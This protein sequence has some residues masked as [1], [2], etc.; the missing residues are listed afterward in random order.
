MGETHITRRGLVAAGGIGAAVAA[1]MLASAD[2][3]MAEAPARPEGAATDEEAANLAI[4]HGFIDSWSDKDFD[5][6][7]VM[8]KYFT[9]DCLARPVDSQ[10]AL[11]GQAA[12]ATVFKGFMAN[13]LTVSVAYQANFAA[14]PVV[15]TRRIDTM[16]NNG[17]PGKAYPIVGV[18][19][20]RSGKIQEWTDYILG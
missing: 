19:T 2:S 3:A 20:L 10:P 4:V 13:G 12:L 5:A 6:E 17:T 7:A 18:F 15:V 11:S 8:A 14:G 9:P 16:V 1:G